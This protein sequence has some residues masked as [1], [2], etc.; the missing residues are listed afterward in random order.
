MPDAAI[1]LPSPQ[2]LYIIANSLSD[3]PWG[4]PIDIG[5]NQRLTNTKLGGSRFGQMFFISP[6]A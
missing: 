4:E 2:K 1:I 5:Q 3:L 6:Q